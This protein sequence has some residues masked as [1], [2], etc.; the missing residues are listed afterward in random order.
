MLVE[1][2]RDEFG[3]AI[4]WTMKGEDAEEISKL[5]T[6]RDLQFWGLDDTVIVYNGRS[7]SNDAENNPG[8]LKWIQH[9]H[10]KHK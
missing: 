2:I 7:E 3:R 9:K 8:I 4:G 5:G 10:R 1:I 6:I